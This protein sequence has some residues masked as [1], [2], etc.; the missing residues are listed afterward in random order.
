MRFQYVVELILFY[1]IY[2]Q[3]CCVNGEEPLKSR[4]REPLPSKYSEM[5]WEDVS[6][7]EIILQNEG[8]RLFPRND[9]G[10][11]NHNLWLIKQRLKNLP[12]GA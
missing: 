10:G 1:H 8:L 4:L 5:T 12:D 2:I 3:I 9:S 11:M 6:N 7:D